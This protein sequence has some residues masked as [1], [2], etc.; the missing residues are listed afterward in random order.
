LP[1]RIDGGTEQ[2]NG[3]LMGTAPFK[4]SSEIYRRKKMIWVIALPC[5]RRKGDYRTKVGER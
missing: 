2:R 5:P 1:N 4:A 3:L